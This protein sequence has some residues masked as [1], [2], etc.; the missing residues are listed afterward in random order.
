MTSGWAPSRNGAAWMARLSE[1]LSYRGART[2]VPMRTTT[3]LKSQLTSAATS[4]VLPKEGQQ[5]AAHRRNHH[6]VSVC[7][8]QRVMDMPF[9]EC[10]AEFVR[11]M[12][13]SLRNRD[14][15]DGSMGFCRG[16]PLAPD[17][18]FG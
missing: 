14:L 15:Y 18:T 11:R 12:C 3:C 7:S 8:P 9:Y 4:G 5:G 17:H 1:K 13:S 16:T 6:C 2:V 10:V